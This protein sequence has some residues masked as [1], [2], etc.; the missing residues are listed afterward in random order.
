MTARC[1][2][3]KQRESSANTNTELG[4]RSSL[5]KHE[6]SRWWL[7]QVSTTERVPR[8]ASGSLQENGEKPT[9]SVGHRFRLE[10]VREN[11]GRGKS[12][13]SRSS[14][15]GRKARESFVAGKYRPDDD[16]TAIFH[17][18]SRQSTGL[19]SVH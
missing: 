13:L 18:H 5:G 7:Y 2:T 17:P 4:D 3:G 1:E 9:C 16:E 12:A 8:K 6:G 10:S 14:V 15:W 11:D 19:A